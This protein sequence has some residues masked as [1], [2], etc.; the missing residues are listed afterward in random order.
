M[1]NENKTV[2]DMKRI[3]LFMF[4]GL[5][6]LSAAAQSPVALRIKVNAVQERFYAGPYAKYSVKYLGVEAEQASSTSCET[7][8]SCPDAGRSRLR[9]SHNTSG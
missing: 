8:A 6:G 1:R 2:L 9:D 5:L 3:L 7:T 4:A